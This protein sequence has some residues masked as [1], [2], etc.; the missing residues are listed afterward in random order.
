MRNLGITRTLVLVDGKRYS[1]TAG[2]TFSC[3]DLNNIPVALIDRVEILKDGASAVYGADAVAGVINLILKKNFTGTTFFANGSMATA[4][5]NRD[6]T[7]G[8]TSGTNFDKGNITISG[9]YQNR[10]PVTQKD[11]DWSHFA[12]VDNL[13]R[14]STSFNSPVVGGRVGS[15]IVPE[16]RVFTSGN[17]DTFGNTDLENNPFAD[18]P[19]AGGEKPTS[20]GL[21][22]FSNRTDRFNWGDYQWLF[23]QLQR[24]NLSSTLNYEITPNINFYSQGFYS[25]WNSTQQLAG[26]PLTQFSPGNPIATDLIIPAGNPLVT[27]LLGAGNEQDLVLN[28]RFTDLGPRSYRQSTDTFVIRAGFNGTLGYGWDYDTFFNY[29]HS[30]K[31]EV[32]TNLNDVFKTQNLFGFRRTY[33]LQPYVNAGYLDDI[34]NGVANDAG[35][36]DPTVCT[37]DPNCQLI[38]SANLTSKGLFL[39]PQQA[40]YIRVNNNQQTTYTLRQWG[41]SLSNS[42]LVQLPYGPLGVVVGAEYRSEAAT[43][44]PDSAVLEG[45]TGNPPLLPTNGEFSVKEIYGEVNVPIVKNLPFAKDIHINVSGR[46]FDYS[47]VG[48][49]QV[50]KIGGNWVPTEDIRFRAT[51]GTAFA[52]PTVFQAFGGGTVSYNTAGD[53]CAGAT[54]GSNAFANCQAQGINPTTFNQLQGQVPTIQFKG[55]PNLLPETSRTYTIGTVITPRWTPGVNFTVDYYHT[56]ITNSIGSLDTGVILANCYNSPNFSSP[57]CGSI[58]P[59]DSQGQLTLVNSP[60]QNLGETRTSGIDFGLGVTEPLPYG[61]GTFSLN[62]QLNWTLNYQIQTGRDVPFTQLAG[63]GFPTGA[64]YTPL[65]RVRDIT[66]AQITRGAW[67]AGYRMRYIG[68]MSLSYFNSNNGYDPALV[69]NTPDVFYHDIFVSTSYRNIDAT[70]GVDNLGDRRPPLAPG[71]TSNTLTSIYD[72]IGRM[73]YVKTSFKF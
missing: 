38:T 37:R 47:T 2:S 54:P 44:V 52:Q 9:S 72:V 11:R 48:A 17:Y 73:V 13:K 3:V 6:G 65:P 69:N 12:L 71:D 25:H 29:G 24:Y 53:P 59:R 33:D 8:F 5:D 35:V 56:R 20:N 58:L 22:G 39:T 55:N 46:W 7:I 14:G 32:E 34:A 43:Y 18:F 31:Q 10:E 70:L 42:N 15:G 66:T 23:S 49:S 67:T 28:K 1:Q 19:T 36:Y 68:G 50:W 61:L 4:G 51:I 62:S 45:L 16:G 30:S 40:A 41:G 21:A 26:Y 64:A 57:L 27:T 63:Q 60:T